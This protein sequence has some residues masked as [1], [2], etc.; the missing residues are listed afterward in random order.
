[1]ANKTGGP[2]NDQLFG[3]GDDDLLSGRGGNDTL[4]GF[5]SNDTLNGDAGDDSLVG[6]HGN[7]DLGGGGGNDKLQGGA[8]RDLLN[9]GRGDDTLDGGGG[10]DF[11]SYSGAGRG[12]KVDL[13]AGTAK[14]DGNDTLL[15]LEHIIGSSHDDTLAGDANDNII[16]GGDGDDALFGRAGDD[17]LHGNKGADRLFGNGGNDTMF[18]DAGNDTLR[19]GLGDDD[20]SGG[21]GSD[22]FVY[23]FHDGNDTISNVQGGSAASDEVLHFVDITAEQLSFERSGSDVLIHIHA[24]TASFPVVNTITV[25]RWFSGVGAKLDHVEATDHTFTTAEIESMIPSNSGGFDGGDH[26]F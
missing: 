4:F 14:G 18:G 2:G 5:N 15:K 16:R 11:V 1:M 22:T 10:R 13:T 24:L 6:G 9:G 8:G 21:R 25:D 7:D 17:T 20:M 19:G 23:A 3:G 26:I 12:V